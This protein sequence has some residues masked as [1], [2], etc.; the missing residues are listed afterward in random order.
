MYQQ[1][2]LLSAIFMLRLLCTQPALLDYSKAVAR[3]AHPAAWACCATH[4]AALL[5]APLLLMQHAFQHVHISE[6]M[7]ID[8]YYGPLCLP[9]RLQLALAGCPCS[10]P[11]SLGALHSTAGSY[12][13]P[14]AA[15]CTCRWPVRCCPPSWPRRGAGWRLTA[16]RGPTRLSST[17]TSECGGG[18]ALAPARRFPGHSSGPAS[19]RIWMGGIHISAG[20]VMMLGAP[21]DVA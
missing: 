17:P 19:P 16:T 10:A 5:S 21:P 11:A 3:L 12:I 8:G 7:C 15:A 18:A 6:M 1:A 14:Q 2:V 20:L 4:R 9:A 13:M